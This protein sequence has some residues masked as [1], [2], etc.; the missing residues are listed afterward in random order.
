MVV[1]LQMGYTP[2]IL[3]L[4]G[5]INDDLPIY[6]LV[7]TN[8]KSKAPMIENQWFALCPIGRCLLAK[9]PRPATKTDRNLTLM[10]GWWFQPPWKILVRLDHWTIIPTIGENNPNVPNHQ[11]DT[12]AETHYWCWNTKM[13]VTASNLELLCCLSFR[14]KHKHN[15]AKPRKMVDRGLTIF[16]PFRMVSPY[17]QASSIPATHSCWLVG[18]DSH[19]GWW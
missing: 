16:I 19:N 15:L 10:P 18:R 3:W 7:F 5:I 12:V 2:T 1:C 13:T 9:T 4:S 6:L 11:T 8:Q 14:R 17:F